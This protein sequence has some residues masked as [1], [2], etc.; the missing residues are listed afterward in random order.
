MKSERLDS[1]FQHQYVGGPRTECRVV[2][3]G[4][5]HVRRSVVIG[6]LLAGVI[7]VAIAVVSGS[8]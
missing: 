3:R 2:L 1:G 5:Q 4:L 8:A 7:G 6:L